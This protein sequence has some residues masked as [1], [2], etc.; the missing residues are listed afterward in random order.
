ML[1]LILTIIIYLIIVIPVGVYLYHVAAGKRT[2][3]DPVF[4]RIDG[5]IYKISGINPNQGMNWKKYALCLLGT[6]AIMILIGYIILRIQSIGLFNPNG[7]GAMEETLSFNTIISFMTNTNLQHY[8]GESGLSY[9]SQMLVITF[10]M[11][12]S[13]STGYAAC[14]AFIRGLAGKTK[15]N[16]GNFFVDL[17]RVTTRVL[18]PFSIVGGLLLVWQGVPQNLTGWTPL[19]EPS[20]PL[21]WALWQRWRL[22]STWEPTAVASLEQTPPHQLRTPRLSLTSLNCIL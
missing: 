13:A 17:V 1:Q 22:L 16:V 7:I 6:N 5:A 12:V 19:K 11:F 3:A 14:I 21:R 4:N 20:K 10:M 15:D 9:L 8:S 2:L 18:L